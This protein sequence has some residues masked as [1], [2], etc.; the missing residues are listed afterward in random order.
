ML[1]AL[2]TGFVAVANA[3]SS[4]DILVMGDWGGS[5]DSPYTTPDELDSAKMMGDVGSTHDVDMV[6]GIG[7]N[8]YDKGVTNEYD[9]RF[10]HTFEDVFT[11]PSLSKIPFYM[12]A[13]N[14]DHD[15][16]VTGEI[17]YSNHSS[18]WRFPDLWYTQ[19]FN[20]PGTSYSLQLLMIDT[21]VLD[22][23][24]HSQDFCDKYNITDCP[25]QPRGPEDPALAQSQYEWIESTL[26][27]SK[28]DFIVVAGHYPVYSIAEHG[29]TQDLVKNL[30]P[31]LT[32]YKVQTYMSGHD[33]TFE[34]IDS[35][36]GVHYVDTGGTHVCD[37][38]TEH[39][40]TIPKDSLKFHGCDD[41]G[42]TRIKVDSDGMTIY[43]YYGKSTEVKYQ[44]PTRKSRK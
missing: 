6:W 20:V 25:I 14:H 13:G 5:P 2:A 29:S 43:Y 34:Y 30:R 37:S 19:T 32:K 4:L 36:D 41:G 23:I 35:G 18:R 10:K 39:M 11:A 24:S 38:S 12:V 42:F 9:S 22:G 15:G 28:A 16:N 3:K 17:Q 7:D 8:M 21:V 1:T 27:A 33:H 40:N 31:L 26:A 44:V